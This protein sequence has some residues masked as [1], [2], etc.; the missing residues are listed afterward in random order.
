M[1]GPPVHLILP[2]LVLLPT[3]ALAHVGH[4][5][6]VAGHDHWVAGAAIGAAILV[7][8]WGAWK[9]R[10]EKEPEVREDDDTTEEAG[11]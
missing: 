1:K 5:G 10:K 3:G 2:L 11:A 7:G 4:L 8:L 9:G 6:E